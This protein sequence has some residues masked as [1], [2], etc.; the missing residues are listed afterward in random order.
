MM[1]QGMA[2]FDL[3]L[4]EPGGSRKSI[5]DRS[6][7]LTLTITSNGAGIPILDVCKNREMVCL[8]R[9]AASESFRA[10][11]SRREAL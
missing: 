3:A 10:V 2:V 8:L 11:N 7:C 1:G 5:A 6:G 4:R 9:R